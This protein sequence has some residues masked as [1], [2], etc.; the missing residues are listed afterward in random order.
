VLVELT[1]HGREVIDAA[2]DAHLALYEELTSGALTDADQRRFIDL[3]RKQT[4]AFEEGRVGG[5]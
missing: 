3:M 5:D 1:Q 2:I 4:R